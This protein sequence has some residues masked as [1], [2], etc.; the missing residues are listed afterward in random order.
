MRSPSKFLKLSGLNI[1]CKRYYYVYKKDELE[2][3]IPNNIKI[4]KSFYEKGNYG[5]IIKK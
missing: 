5:I 3:L 1:L 2:S 4:I